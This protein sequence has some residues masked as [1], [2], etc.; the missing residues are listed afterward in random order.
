MSNRVFIPG[1]SADLRTGRVSEDFGCYVISKNVEQRLPVLATD[2]SASI[3]LNSWQFLRSRNR[4]KIFAFCIMPDH[5]HLAMC[6]MPGQTLAKV[7][8][9]TGKF[10]SRQ[11]NQLFGKRGTFWQEGYHDRH[12]RTASELHELCRYI[13]HNPVRKGLVKS[14]ELWPCSSA[15]AA[16]KYM[17]NREWWP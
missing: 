1:R 11:L 2:Q 8:E 4:I 15:F 6:L 7:M 17:L 12:C 16:N 3:L 5:F 9:D 13:E 14:A 10:T